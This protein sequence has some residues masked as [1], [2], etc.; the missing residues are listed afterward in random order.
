MRIDLNEELTGRILDVGGGGEGVVG[1]RYGRNVIAIDNC[2]EELDEAPDA[3]EKRVM[4]AAALEF[5]AETF[6]HVTFFYSL[7]Y[8]TEE[9]QRKAVAEAARVLKNGGMLWIWDAAVESAY[10]EP[11]T[12]DLTVGLPGREIHT[13]YGI[14]KRDSQS[15]DG[16]RR[17]AETSGLTVLR[18]RQNEGQFFLC[19]RKEA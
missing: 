10:P 4:D 7:L 1:L 13:T 15:A 18:A 6:D 3:C 12:V 17:M 2:P 9:T 11:F 5:P 19:C 8:M 14:V 16:I